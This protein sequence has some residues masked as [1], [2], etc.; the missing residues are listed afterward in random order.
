MAIPVILQAALMVALAPLWE[1][2]IPVYLWAVVLLGV[3]AW[4]VLVWVVSSFRLLL[5]SDAGE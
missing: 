1:I 3:A 4:E 2:N 5:F